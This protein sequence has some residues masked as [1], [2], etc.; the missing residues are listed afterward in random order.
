MAGWSVFA[1]NGPVFR[2]ALERWPAAPYEV[3]IYHRGALGAEDQKV[4][5]WLETCS[6]QEEMRANLLVGTVD[7]DTLEAGEAKKVWG[8]KPEP[9]LP[10]VVVR[11]PRS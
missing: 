4:V 1:C 9:E 7:L 6:F 11:Y 3:V 8:D 10:R 5:D 2:Y